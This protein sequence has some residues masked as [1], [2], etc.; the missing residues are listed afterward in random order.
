MTTVT[1]NRAGAAGFVTFGGNPPD[2]HPNELPA[3]F[4]ACLGKT[5]AE[6]DEKVGSMARGYGYCASNAYNR[7]GYCACVNNA[8]PC[9]A[10]A[11]AACANAPLAYKT[12]NMVPGSVGYTTCQNQKVCVN[13][14]VLG[15]VGN[16]ITDA[17]QS[18]ALDYK[19]HPVV[20]VLILLVIIFEA[21]RFLYIVG[22]AVKD[23]INDPN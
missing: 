7:S 15:G 8:L 14:V 13:E 2:P 21:L 20:M 6:C 11:A 3:D 17:H 1:D 5:S 10:V 16:T 18:C 22:G 12:M 19:A 4:A 23:W 9:P